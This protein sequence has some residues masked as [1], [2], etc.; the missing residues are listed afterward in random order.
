MSTL[1]TI[2]LFLPFRKRTKI[3]TTNRIILFLSIM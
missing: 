2:S 1:F 3:Q